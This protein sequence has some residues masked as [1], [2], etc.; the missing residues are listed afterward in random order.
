METSSEESAQSD[1]PVRD[2]SEVEFATDPG[3][4]AFVHTLIKCTEHYI[5]H[6]NLLIE[7]KSQREEIRGG[8]WMIDGLRINIQKYRNCQ[9]DMLD[10]VIQ[11]S[12]DQAQALE[13]TVARQRPMLD[14]LATRLRQNSASR[15]RLLQDLFSKTAR[16]LDRELMSE[17]TYQGVAFDHEFAKALA[18]L[19]AR[20]EHLSRCKT[21]LDALRATMMHAQAELVAWRKRDHGDDDGTVLKANRRRAV[22]QF[23]QQEM[24]FSERSKTQL[25]QEVK[26]FAG[27]AYSVLQAAGILQSRGP[28]VAPST[29]AS[30]SPISRPDEDRNAQND[31]S[32]VEENYHESPERRRLLGRRA[33]AAKARQRLLDLQWGYKQRLAEF[34]ITYPNLMR[35]EYDQLYADARGKSYE[36]DETEAHAAIAQAEADLQ[37]AW[38]EALEAG[39]TD[40]PGSSSGQGD[41]SEDGKIGTEGSS[42]RA[43][44]LSKAKERRPHIRQWVGNVARSGSPVS[45]SLPPH[46]VE[47]T[48][49]PRKKVK[50]SWP[51]EEGGPEVKRSQID[52]YGRSQAQMRK[53]YEQQEADRL[54]RRAEARRA[55]EREER[56]RFH[57]QV[58]RD[59]RTR[60]L[61]RS[62]FAQ[63]CIVS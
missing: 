3:D 52:K 34:M 4:N 10:S 57:G 33:A 32:D 6:E 21:E 37:I 55:A 29:P 39:V 5:V 20:A 8:Q 47:K 63:W 35:E 56:R 1:R 51:W 41:D 2:Y 42:H 45:P 7:Q 24:I 31:F 25:E 38:G 50:P 22:T 58:A 46:R 49:A 60:D 62:L 27:T 59:R 44:R 43:L 15:K 13:E 26:F 18:E 19:Q 53:R 23:H 11:E 17:S 16:H 9:E 30:L 14:T 54:E 40:L 36:A 61:D 48:K 12:E 28:P